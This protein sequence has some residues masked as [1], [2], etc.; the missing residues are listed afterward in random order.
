MSRGIRAIAILV[1][2]LGAAAAI[3][4]GIFQIRSIDVKGNERYS[5]EQIRDDLIYDFKTRNT[6]YFSW[7]YRSAAPAADAP[8][9]KSVQ[10]DML[11]PTSVRIVVKESQI[12]GRV[13]YEG[14]NVYYDADGN[15]QEISDTIYAK[16]PLVAGVEIET[17]QLY[18]KLVTKNT[19]WLR[20][21]LNITQLLVKSELIPDSVTFD[22]NQNMILRFGPV[23][24]ALGQDEYL[25]EKIANLV[26]IYPQVEG[27]AGTLN[28]EGFTGKNEAITFKAD[29][30]PDQAEE[31]ESGEETP[32]QDSGDS[33]AGEGAAAQEPAQ[34]A[35]QEE[36]PQEEAPQEEAPQEEAPQSTTFMVFDS[37]GTLRYDAHVV[38]GQVVDAYG[39]PIDGCY[40]NENGNVVDA[41]WNEIDP[42]TGQLAQ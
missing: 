30:E 22:A 17:P 8:Y 40:V 26:S 32:V 2:V 13:Q 35:P 19:S 4:L 38:G 39:N 36:A 23:T 33:L 5:A 24:V 27:E 15:V 42:A 10:A 3:V 28:M 16:I 25:E 20:T 37:S 9:L 21:M 7:K 12:V 29:S 11:S 1:V 31:T 14:Q 18:Q 6:L 41:Y 34:E